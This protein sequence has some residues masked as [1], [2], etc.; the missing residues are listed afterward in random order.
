MTFDEAGYLENRTLPAVSKM[1]CISKFVFNTKLRTQS[2]FG[3][4]WDSLNAI[5][6]ILSQNLKSTGN[7]K[8]AVENKIDNIRS[9][10]V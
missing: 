6:L 9:I 8:P 10:L 4:A 5:Q 2:K 1:P 7:Q 3:V